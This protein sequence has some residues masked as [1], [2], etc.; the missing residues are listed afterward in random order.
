MHD[1]KDLRGTASC[2]VLGGTVVGLLNA[3]CAV[4]VD[5]HVEKVALTL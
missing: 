4:S 1:A 5:M 2:M 3:R